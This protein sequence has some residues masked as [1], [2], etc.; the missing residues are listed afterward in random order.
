MRWPFSFYAGP[1]RLFLLGAGL[2]CRLV[3]EVR[4]A[5]VPRAEATRVVRR[6]N[7]IDTIVDIEPFRMMVH[8]FRL[9]GD[10][11]HEAEGLVEILEAE[12]LL[13]GVPAG[14]VLPTRKLGK[15]SCAIRR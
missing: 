7:D 15:G 1:S 8:P 4:Q 6:Q 14:D 13:D 11:R 9:Q 12:G 2:R 5:D 10:A 3:D